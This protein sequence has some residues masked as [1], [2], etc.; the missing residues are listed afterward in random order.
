M[1][2]ERKQKITGKGGLIIGA[3]A[4][5]VVVIAS[6]VGVIIYLLQSREAEAEPEREL[7]NVVITSENVESVLEE[8]IERQEKVAPGYYTVTMNTTWHFTTGD[9]ASYDAVVENVVTN[10][11]DVYFDIVLE[12]DE[13]TVLYKSPVIPRGGRL[14][15]IALD[16]SLDAGTYNC[17]VIYHLIDDEQNTLSTLRITLR[18]IVEG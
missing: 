4:V 1:V 16:E 7:R 9:E 12:D 14:G 11:N 15:E 3:A 13:D 17:V 5:A 8:I 10:T 6:L 18:I 2:M